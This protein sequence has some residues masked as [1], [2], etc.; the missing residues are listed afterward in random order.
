LR[1]RGAFDYDVAV[2]MQNA[3]ADKSKSF[4]PSLKKNSR[5]GL[6]SRSP[7]AR[8]LRDNQVNYHL[9][10]MRALCPWLE[11]SDIYVAR[12]FAELELL[13][14]RAYAELRARTLANDEGRSRRLLDDYRRLVALSIVAARELG[15]SPAARM[16]IKAN[17]ANAALDLVGQFA[18][19]EARS[20]VA[21]DA[22]PTKG[23][24]R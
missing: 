7:T 6:Y 19:D 21:S 16:A 24:D 2:E 18:A 5:T 1:A 14:S 13:A 15:L 8:R 23:D 11:R 12:R 22:K 10:K 3:K 9:R 17:S 4:V 20:R